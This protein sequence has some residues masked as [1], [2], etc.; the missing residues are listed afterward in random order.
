[1]TK[2]KCHIMQAIFPFIWMSSFASAPSLILFPGRFETSA[3]SSN[4]WTANNKFW[5]TLRWRGSWMMFWGGLFVDSY[6]LRSVAEE[7][8]TA[9]V[10]C[11]CL[12]RVLSAISHCLDL[13]SSNLPFMRV[14]AWPTAWT[15][16]RPPRLSDSVSLERYIRFSMHAL[17]NACGCFVGAFALRRIY[18][19]IASSIHFASSGM[20]TQRAFLQHGGGK[21]SIVIWGPLK[22][23]LSILFPSP[24]ILYANDSDI[25][26]FIVHFTFL[27][28]CKFI[29]L[30]PTVNDF[31]HALTL[32]ISLIQALI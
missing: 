29:R 13:I 22:R 15:C 28:V 16:F 23:V 7:C 14:S 12:A 5:S 32:S 9:L 1:M 2:S 6:I 3:G 19:R 30:S 21:E 20:L 8:S 17:V 31:L 25:R 24:Q 18:A 27:A 26:K 10:R 4:I 11:S